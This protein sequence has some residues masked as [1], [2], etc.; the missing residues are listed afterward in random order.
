VRRSL[1]LGDLARLFE[2]LGYQG[3]AQTFI[4]RIVGSLHARP[5]KR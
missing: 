3:A 2:P 1:S 5:G 4:D